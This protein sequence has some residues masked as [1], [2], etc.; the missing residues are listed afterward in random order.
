MNGEMKGCKKLNE[1][2]TKCSKSITHKVCVC[3][4]KYPHDI[5]SEC[6]SKL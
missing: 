3:D 5:Y 1:I 4:K 2:C 6:F